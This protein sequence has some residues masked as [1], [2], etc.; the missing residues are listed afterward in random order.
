[1]LNRQVYTSING[2][3]CQECTREGG[4]GNLWGVGQGLADDHFFS[5][6]IMERLRRM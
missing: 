6:K 4:A 2:G 3:F 5:W 1:M